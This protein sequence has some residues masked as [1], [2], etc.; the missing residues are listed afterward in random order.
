MRRAHHRSG[1]RRRRGIPLATRSFD[2]SA[3]EVQHR[4]FAR[5]RSFAVAASVCRCRRRGRACAPARQGRS[6]WGGHTCRCCCGGS[7]RTWAGDWSPRFSLLV[8]QQWRLSASGQRSA[9]GT[10][11]TSP[12]STALAIL[13]STDGPRC[14]FPLSRAARPFRSLDYERAW[15]RGARHVGPGAASE[16][17]PCL[18]CLRPKA[19]KSLGAM[20]NSRRSDLACIRAPVR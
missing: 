2:R 15:P 6:P 20:G 19:H 9:G 8:S 14:R 12:R 16:D 4:R 10:V 5:Q 11:M 1:G 13:G 3:D 17:T 18:I 7:V